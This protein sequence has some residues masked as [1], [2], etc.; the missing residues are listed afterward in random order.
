M[1]K[2]IEKILDEFRKLACDSDGTIHAGGSRINDIESFLEQSLKQI[3]EK[4]SKRREQEIIILADKMEKEGWSLDKFIKGLLILE[5][6]N[7][8]KDNY[9]KE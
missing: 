5:D 6:T 4:A 2:G 1:N 3:A 7:N 9:L 8:N